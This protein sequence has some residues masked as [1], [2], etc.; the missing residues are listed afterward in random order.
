MRKR[1]RKTMILRVTTWSSLT[2]SSLSMMTRRLYTLATSI[3]AHFP[4]H[5]SLTILGFSVIGCRIKHRLRNSF[6]SRETLTSRLM[7]KIHS[8]LL[9]LN[10]SWIME[11][12]LILK[13]W[14]LLQMKMVDLRSQALF[15]CTTWNKSKVKT[16]SAKRRTLQTL[17]TK[18]NRLCWCWMLLK[19]S[20]KTT[21][22][23]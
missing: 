8:N 11:A 19:I 6:W 23:G 14:Y 18:A 4:R 12:W 17:I 5:P 22:W 20:S 16:A 1:R 3:A 10:S 2:N 13:W 9:L 7:L 21:K 15:S